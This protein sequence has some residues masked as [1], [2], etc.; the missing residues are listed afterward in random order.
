MAGI[1]PHRQI[2]CEQRRGDYKTPGCSDAD[3]PPAAMAQKL[4][5]RL[6]LPAV[7]GG[8]VPDV[9]PPAASA[10]APAHVVLN[11]S[12]Q[13]AEARVIGG[14]PPPG[15]PPT[16]PVVKRYVP[17]TSSSLWVPASDQFH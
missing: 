14:L 1:L 13:C 3:P 2:A 15:C 11:N 12:V 7:P 8:S 9:P 5:D 6:N 4:Y 16:E 17:A 10:A